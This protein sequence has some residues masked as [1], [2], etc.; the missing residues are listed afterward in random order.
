MPAR[1]Y[2]LLTIGDGL[3]AQIPALLLSVAVAIIVTR[4]SRAQ[5]M[6]KQIMSAGAS[7]SRAA[8]GVAAAPCWAVIGLI[9]GMPNFAFL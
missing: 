7:A 5:D 6:G 2:A 1:I 8:L 4:V 9:P 3:V